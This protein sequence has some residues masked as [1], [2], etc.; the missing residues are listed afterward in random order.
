MLITN[1]GEVRLVPNAKSE[2]SGN[3]DREVRLV[4]SV[5]WSWCVEQAGSRTGCRTWLLCFHEWA[6]CFV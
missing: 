1:T 3:V 4:S 2:G 5:L 6:W